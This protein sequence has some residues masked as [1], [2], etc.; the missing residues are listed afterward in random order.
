[1]S[2]LELETIYTDYKITEDI[3]ERNN[4]YDCISC[5]MIEFSLV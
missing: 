2:F 1:M 3:N 4:Q 5:Y